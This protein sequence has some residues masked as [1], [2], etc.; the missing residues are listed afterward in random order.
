MDKYAAHFWEGCALGEI[1]YQHCSACGARQFHARAFC[2][3]PTVLIVD[4][5]LSNLDFRTAA[6]IQRALETFARDRTTL[7]AAHRYDMTLEADRVLVLIDGRIAQLGT[8]AELRGRVGW[9]RDWAVH[10][11]ELGGADAKPEAPLRG[12]RA[13]AARE[14]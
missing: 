10:T 14:A 1:R 7:I 12:E 11:E 9:Y 4:E 6:A 8:T 13:P 3:R 5:A 2:A